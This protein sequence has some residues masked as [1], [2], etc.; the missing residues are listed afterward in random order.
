MDSFLP[1]IVT[2]R[3]LA[4]LTRF[5]VSGQYK[6]KG[7]QPPHH[8]I[9]QTGKQSWG[10]VTCAQHPT[11]GPG[12]ARLESRASQA[13]CFPSLPFVTSGL[14]ELAWGGKVVVMKF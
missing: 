8:L 3:F 14:K 13:S 12:Q 5:Y 6:S 4:G 11:A 7:Q 9:L 2:E 1:D 10:A